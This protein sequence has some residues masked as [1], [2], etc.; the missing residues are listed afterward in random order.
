MDK[1]IGEMLTRFGSDKSTK[2]NY[3]DVYGIIFNK[4][5]PNPKILEIGLGSSNTEIL[6][7][8]G[9]S[10]SPGASIR[11]LMAYFPASDITGADID[12]SIEVEGASILF[13]DQTNPSTF[14]NLRPTGDR[15]YDLIIEDGLHAVNTSMYSLIFGIEN[16]SSDGIIVIE[17]ISMIESVLDIWR[18]VEIILS[19][20]GWHVHLL[21]SKR[22][23]VLCVSKKRFLAI[24]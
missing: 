14:Q 18:S 24:S 21:K 10:G 16:I 2:H 7:S 17:D 1:K 22:A 23:A 9:A 12:K 15:P 8:M 19:S 13:V 6:S 4:L 20:A 3:H 5:P 11:A